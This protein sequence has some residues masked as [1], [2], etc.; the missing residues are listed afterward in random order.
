MGKQKLECKD[1]IDHKKI[2][3]NSLREIS[4][5]QKPMPEVYLIQPKQPTVNKPG[6][7][8]DEQLTH[9]FEK[10]SFVIFKLPSNNH[11]YFS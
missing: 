2:R 7:L 3:R 11:Y 9:F 10:V 6:Q 1:E 8:T 5:N 4:V